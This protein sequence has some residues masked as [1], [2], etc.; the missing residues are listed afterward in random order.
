MRGRDAGDGVATRIGAGLLLGSLLAAR[1]V[2]AD[3]VAQPAATP[4]EIAAWVERLGSPQYAQREAAARSLVAAGRAAIEPLLA[5]IDGDDFEVATRGVEILRGM[6]ASADDPLAEEAERR[7][8]TVAAG[9][10]AV[11]RLAEAALEFHVLG[12]SASA[13]ERLESL[14]AVFRERA[15]PG[16]G[17][18]I[19]VEFH[20][21]W[22]GGPEDWRL[23]P[24]LRGVAQVSVHGVPLDET[25]VG[26]L[27]RVAGVR[28][29]DL[30]GTGAPAAAVAALVARLPDAVVDVRKGGRL[31]VSS[32]VQAGRCELSAV[33]PGA[34]A[35]R[36]GLR[37]GDVVVAIDGE[38]VDSFAALTARV[39]R[40]GP[41][42]V[43]RLAVHR[44]GGG[45]VER[46][47]V[48]V[49]LDAW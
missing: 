14:G 27:G 11:A 9:R 8:E 48:D 41:G 4:A 21:G 34:A 40:H 15:G 20:G 19:E 32:L 2:A 30:F 23:L 5:A 47:D 18:G 46:L 10:A 6:L 33:Q 16:V 29:I 3:G 1:A 28:R 26:V 42:E 38:P 13:R 7:L 24:R 17:Q 25:A 12:Q 43:V 36:A 31:G 22:R 49:R 44:G 39:A 35:A 45:E 37:P